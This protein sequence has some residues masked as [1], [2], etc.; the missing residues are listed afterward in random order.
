M[1]APVNQSA[2]LP[3]G[4]QATQHGIVTNIITIIHRCSTLVW[5]PINM[6]AFTTLHHPQPEARGPEDHPRGP[7]LP[8]PGYGGWALVS[9]RGRTVGGVLRFTVMRTPPSWTPAPWCGQGPA[10]YVPTPSVLCMQS[11]TLLAVLRMRMQD[12]ISQ[13]RC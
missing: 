5:Y 3:T 11:A 7:G 6:P 13:V 8:V 1:A 2:N 12:M 9:A 10:A 4:T